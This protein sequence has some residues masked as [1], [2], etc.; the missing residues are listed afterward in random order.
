MTAAATT[1]ALPPYVCPNDL[2]PLTHT[3]TM[4]RCSGGHEFQIVGGIP[5]FVPASTY[6]DSFSLQW[7]HFRRTQL[8]SFTGT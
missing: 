7:N 4:Y 1:N 3:E 8:D 5:R 6:A 2:L